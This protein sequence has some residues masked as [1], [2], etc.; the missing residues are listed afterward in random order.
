MSWLRFGGQPNL[1]LT[2]FKEYTVLQNNG[3]TS[4]G[5][6]T[7]AAAT[8]NHSPRRGTIL[9]VD[10]SPTI[11]RL[12]AATLER[13]GYQ[14]VT[15]ADG[16]EALARMNDISPDL[17]FLDITMP[18]LDGYQLCKIIKGNED[19]KQIPVVML[20]GK[21]GF[22]DKV[23]GRMAG[24]TDYVTKPFKPSALL[25]VIGKHIR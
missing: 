7:I 11:C 14:V 10:D 16:L 18:R 22:F 12:V 8:P 17:I 25:Q 6:G 5:N 20:S 15:A 19:T 1:S 3:L 2:L 4:A 23:K 21:D 24:A 9:V 13:R